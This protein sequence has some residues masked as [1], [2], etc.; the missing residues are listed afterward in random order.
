M[1]SEKF[2]QE[3]IYFLK[4]RDHSD[5]GNRILEKLQERTGG[6]KAEKDSGRKQKCFP[7]IEIAGVSKMNQ[8][9]Q[10]SES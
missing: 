2:K 8:R 5:M 10:N 9:M 6:K 1:E 4:D 7:L 3:P